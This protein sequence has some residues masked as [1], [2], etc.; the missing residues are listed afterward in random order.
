MEKI[1]M[2]KKDE[3]E[4]EVERNE[5]GLRY[6]LPTDVILHN[7]PEDCWVSFLGK[8]CDVTPIVKEYENEKEVKPLL[9]H[10]GKDISHWFDERTQDIK[11]MI[12]PV[13]GVKVPYCPHGP[14]PHVHPQVPSTKWQPLPGV[15]RPYD[16]LPWWRN[17]K[18]VVGL[19]SKNPR[20]LK[21]VNTAVPESHRNSLAWVSKL[22][23]YNKKEN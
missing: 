4:K 3:G 20:P 15:K 14:I 6:Y 9:A 10:A 7:K 11:Y 19:L 23:T 12:H 16:G 21:I 5:F 17:K 22:I 8:V 18:Y 13:T 2:G 1:W